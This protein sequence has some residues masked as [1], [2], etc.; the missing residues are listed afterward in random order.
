MLER[1]VPKQ[2]HGNQ[3]DH[4]NH[5]RDRFPDQQMRIGHQLRA[6]VPDYL[7]RGLLGDEDDADGLLL[8]VGAEAGL[9]LFL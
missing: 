1:S 4:E 8:G 6:G 9:V 2:R 7:C 5:K 3:G